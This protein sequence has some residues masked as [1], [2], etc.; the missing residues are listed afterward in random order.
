MKSPVIFLITAFCI[1]TICSC[2][3]AKETINKG[4]EAVGET[5]TEF[6]EGVS[7]GVD[8]TLECKI[9]L[10]EELID[11]GVKTGKFYIE[12]E[13]NR[14]DNKLVIYIIT[15]KT[16][17]DT[18]TFTAKDKKGVEFGRK[19]LVLNTKA[20]DASYYDVIFDARTDIEVKSTIEIY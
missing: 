18:L 19:K 20:G 14:K 16:L 4:G 10:S 9:S 5:A 2:Q 6:I 3:K 13:G 1:L 17:N 11:K 7:E 8:R 15:E 12:D